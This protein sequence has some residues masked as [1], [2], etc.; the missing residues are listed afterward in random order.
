MPI[1]NDE[2]EDNLV[3]SLYPEPDEAKGVPAPITKLVYALPAT[4]PFTHDDLLWR[5]VA[6]NPR[7]RTTGNRGYFLKNVGV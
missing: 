3:V 6:M 7:E 5:T 2:D 4:K 1:S